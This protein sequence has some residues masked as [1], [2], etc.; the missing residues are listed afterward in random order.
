MAASTSAAAYRAALE[1]GLV[2][3]LHGQIYNRAL[4]AIPGSTA[5][6]IW[7]WLTENGEARL[8][9]HS[10]SP[11]FRELVRLGLICETEK[12]ACRITGVNCV[13]WTRLDTPGVVPV[14]RE[15]P[16]VAKLQQIFDYIA[17]SENDTILVQSADSA[18]Q[19]ILDVAAE[20]E[21]KL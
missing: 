9:Q 17:N 15:R 10:C 8:S 19:H 4:K 21:I 5:N 16:I 11:R 6:E 12:R 20:L 14:V 7:R 2:D 1:N 18:V 3:D 13:T